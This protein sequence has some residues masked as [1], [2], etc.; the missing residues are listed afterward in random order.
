MKA[1]LEKKLQVPPKAKK[2]PE[3]L[4]NHFKESSNSMDQLM[5]IVEI[6]ARGIGVLRG[7]PKIVQVL[8]DV[9][10]N[11]QEPKS[12]KALERATK[13]A[14]LASNEVAKDF[15]VLHGFA[16][17]ALWS[18]LEHFVKGLVALWLIHRRDALDAPVVQKLRV[19]FG[20][21]MRL[22]KSEQAQF[23]VELLEQDLALPHNHQSQNGR[24]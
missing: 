9:E 8:A 22:Q 11:S 24:S 21:Y 5:Q 13:E 18:W 19:R 4:G 7:M 20:E 16:V 10:G 6:S 15:P 1:K 14:E 17:V 12:V 2:L 3:W 23:L